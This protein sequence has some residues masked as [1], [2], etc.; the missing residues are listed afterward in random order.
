[1]RFLSKIFYLYYDGFRNMTLGKSLWLV[2]IL[3]LLIIFGFLKIFI[4]DKSLKTNFQTQEEKSEFVSK[5]L[6]EF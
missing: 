6:T 4:Y 5:N 2:I 1:M 3:K